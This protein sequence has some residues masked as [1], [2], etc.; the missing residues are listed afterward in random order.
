MLWGNAGDKVATFRKLRDS[1]GSTILLGMNEVNE[2]SQ[3]NLDVSTGISLWNA[4]IRP[5]GL[6]GFTLVSPAVTSAPSGITWFQGFFKDCGDYD[7]QAHCG[8][9][10]LA[11]HYY[12][13]TAE[14]LISYLEKFWQTFGIPIWLTE[15]ACQDF[16]GKNNQCDSGQV[17]A[18][19]ET[20]TSWM[21]STD[22]VHAYFAFGILHDMWNVNYLNQLMSSNCSPTS[23]GYFYINS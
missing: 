16:T 10:F 14:G 17:W 8:V 2:P 9:D 21:D 7:G 4:E 20:A 11:V 12:G 5:Y 18:F 22:Y 13:N 15:F 6:K 1:G 19:M 3:A 23:L